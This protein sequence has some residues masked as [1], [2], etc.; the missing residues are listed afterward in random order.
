M[1]VLDKFPVLPGV[2]LLYMLALKCEYKRY[3]AAMPNEHL[4]FWAFAAAYINI[5]AATA[6][7]D[8]AAAVVALVNSNREQMRLNF[9]LEYAEA[10]TMP[11][12]DYYA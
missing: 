4:H 3:Q 9:P 1:G 5:L 10:M 6:E 11:C 2:D 8:Y 7:G 12:A